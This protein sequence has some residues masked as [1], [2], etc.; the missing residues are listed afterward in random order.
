MLYPIER[1]LF[2]FSNT[3]LDSY[4]F[5]IV[6]QFASSILD[7]Y[8]SNLLDNKIT[9]SLK[10]KGR[11]H[12]KIKV[13]ENV[14]LEGNPKYSCKNY[15]TRGEYRECVESA[16][17]R[18][19]SKYLHCTPPWMTDNEDLWCKE[20]E[21]FNSSTSALLHF[22]YLNSL[23]VVEAKPQECLSPCKV[24]KYKASEIGIKKWGWEGL[25]IWFENE[26]DITKSSLQMD[27]IAV[28]S[29]IGG[30]IGISKNF[31]WILIVILSSI[32]SFKSYLEGRV[33]NA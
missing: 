26:V 18:K 9:T 15:N 3:S 28:L 2:D 27:E 7:Q 16:I 4:K 13:M 25:T 22:D 31:L 12:Y 24:K 11:R 14:H 33:T 1:L 19:N 23:G 10:T 8:N 20:K 32:C 21:T 17:I 6:D 30:Y 29:K 5:F